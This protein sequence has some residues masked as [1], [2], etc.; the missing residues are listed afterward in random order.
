MVQ[1]PKNMVDATLYFFTVPD[2][3]QPDKLD[4]YQ[5]AD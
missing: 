2:P 1:N 5:G 3:G 4:T